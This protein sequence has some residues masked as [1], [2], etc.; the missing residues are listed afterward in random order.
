LEAAPV[1]PEPAAAAPPTTQRS[2][3][4]PHENWRNVRTTAAEIRQPARDLGEDAVA[5]GLGPGRASGREPDLD[6]ARTDPHP[7]A[8]TSDTD[9]EGRR[10]VV[11]DDTLGEGAI[12]LAGCG[13]A[14]LSSGASGGRYQPRRRQA[15]RC[16]PGSPRTDRTAPTRRMQSNGVALPRA[17][18]L[19]NSLPQIPDH[20]RAGT[21]PDSTARLLAGFSERGFPSKSTFIIDFKFDLI[22][23]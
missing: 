4:I 16:L 23:Y 12:P 21:D 14:L 13:S 10:P 5:V 9:A 1:S 22:G 19:A 7:P 3:V 15:D 2:S 6:P 17:P 20:T 11:R 18:Y 8:A